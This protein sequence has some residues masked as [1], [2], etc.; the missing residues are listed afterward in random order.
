MSAKVKA[1]RS[2]PSTESVLASG[3]RVFESHHGVSFEMPPSTH[4][5]PELLYIQDG[6]GQICLTD[7]TAKISIACSRYDCVVVPADTEHVIVD[8]PDKPLSLFGLA[9]DP[10]RIPACADLVPLLPRGKIPRHQHRMLNVQ[11]RIR[12]LLFL[13]ADPSP[14]KQVSAVAEAMEL[15]ARLASLPGGASSTFDSDAFRAME[16]YMHWLAQ[17]FYEPVTLDQAADACGVSRRRFTDLFRQRTGKTW[18]R[19]LHELRINHAIGLLRET[20]TQVTSIAF[21]SGFDELSTFYRVF[22]SVT[23]RRPLDY[24]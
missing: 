1:R 2:F 6:H 9:I 3:I 17:N 19:Y 24:R 15:F 13:S 21:Q 4:R 23:G 12:R 11:Q 7:K 22:K 18:L 5:F 14:I 8:E 20:E 10:S 16:N